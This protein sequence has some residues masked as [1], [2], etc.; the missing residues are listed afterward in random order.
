[1]PFC[2]G[3]RESFF[4]SRAKPD[5]WLGQIV[6]GVKLLKV[7]RGVQSSLDGEADFRRIGKAQ[8]WNH[9]EEQKCNSAC[10]V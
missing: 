3:V 7:G 4:G 2:T 6:D 9:E 10:H 8:E 5:D 1:M